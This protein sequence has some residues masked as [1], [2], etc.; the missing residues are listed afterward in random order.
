[1][2]K[3][4]KTAFCGHGGTLG[5]RSDDDD[6][7]GKSFLSVESWEFLKE[8]EGPNKT[9]T[10]N[11]SWINKQHIDQKTVSYVASHHSQLTLFVPLSPKQKRNNKLASKRLWPILLLDRMDFDV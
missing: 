1:V 10:K 2:K 9:S 7:D 4:F 3:I 8:E 11:C 5:V 6:D